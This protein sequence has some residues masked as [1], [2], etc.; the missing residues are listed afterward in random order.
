MR[1]KQGPYLKDFGLWD[2]EKVPLHIPHLDFVIYYTVIASSYW[3]CKD[4]E[5]TTLFLTSQY[6]FSAAVLS[7]QGRRPDTICSSKRHW[8]FEEAQKH[9]FAIGW[10]NGTRKIDW[11]VHQDYRDRIWG[12]KC[13]VVSTV[14]CMD[15][16][17]KA[18]K[19]CAIRTL[20]PKEC[21][22]SI[23]RSIGNEIEHDL[24]IGRQ[25][26]S[27]SAQ[28]IF[29]LPTFNCLHGVHCVHMLSQ[30]LWTAG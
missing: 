23:F 8:D 6:T 7:S 18:F 4:A 26:C 17:V 14:S 1:R 22:S 28:T 19:E 21:M 30:C 5:K 25:F 20:K 15:L 29:V 2:W 10:C 12:W 16:N 3:M 13:S 27:Q 11:R 9:T 24:I